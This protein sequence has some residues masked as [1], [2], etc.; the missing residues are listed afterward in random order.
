MPMFD[1]YVDAQAS[2]LTS[3][4]T[5]DLAMQRPEWQATGGSADAGT[6]V[7][8]AKN[9]TVEH[10]K[11][12][13]LIQLTVMDTSPDVAVAEMQS[14]VGA[15]QTLYGERDGENDARTLQILEDRRT[16]LSNESKGLNDRI[17]QVAS[18][19]GSDTLGHV[20]DY[21]LERLNQIETELANVQVA[22]AGTE[23][24][25][26]AATVAPTDSPSTAP[27][28]LVRLDS[29]AL[30]RQYISK[31]DDLTQELERLR[32]RLGPH[33]PQ[34]REGEALL[35]KAEEHITQR[36]SDLRALPEPTVGQDGRILAGDDPEQLRLRQAG[37]KTLYES[38]KTELID[39]GRK[40][41][42]LQNLKSDADALK[43]RLE[44]TKSRI[45]QL[46]VESTV[47]GRINVLSNGDKPLLP[48][49]DKRSSLAV[50]G[51][52]LGSGLGLGFVVLLGLFD[53]RLD[54]VADAR[55]GR[56]RAESV[57]GI[58]PVLPKDLSDPEEAATAAFCVHQIRTLLQI[59]SGRKGQGVYAITSPTAG[60]GK[61]SLA[62]ALA[63]SFAAAGSRT[64]L[65]D[66]DL[67]AAGLSARMARMGR[68]RIGQVL[69]REGLITE[70]QLAEAV[71]AAASAHEPLGQLLIQFG[72][73]SEADID[74]ALAVQRATTLGLVEAL[75]GESVAECATGTGVDDLFILPLNGSALAQIGR[76]SPGTLR[77]IITEARKEFD[78][79]LIDTG[80]LLGS[81]EASIV[82]A[83]ADSVILT[84]SRG[85]LRPIV[86]RALAQ[87]EQVG[88]K[89]AG[90]VFNRAQH[91]DVIA[92]TESSWSHR[93]VSSGH[94][95]TAI[96]PQ[97][98]GPIGSAVESS[99]RNATRV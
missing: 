88:G 97:R 32:V 42:L 90:L 44:E 6:S 18:E 63:L 56:R 98:L 62:I 67:V 43:T 64:L 37:L 48:A 52:I 84:L 81:I 40:N 20:Y 31:R 68:R 69:L 25:N 39:I 61:T 22:L 77:R 54:T 21:K 1:A 17:L 65:I 73:V 19:F 72:W 74:H 58:L 89:L 60:D 24:K 49:K 93:S 94:G 30:M 27:A 71:E 75:G 2:L 12:S 28:T 96:A 41:L 78:T 14:V 45:E 57:L 3:Q 9:L 34:V 29:D 91:S 10:T 99:T 50:A 66:C 11:G 46:N 16:S 33:H 59:Q 53:H 47:S 76:L 8:F 13:E 4:R 79:V 7:K 92:S 23:K 38:A 87:I 86:Q 5:L 70:Q 95:T 35:A 26:P 55:A 82:T 80:P 15:Y 83:E 85:T 51:G 36:E